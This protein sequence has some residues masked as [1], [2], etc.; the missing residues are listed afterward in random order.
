LAAAIVHGATHVWAIFFCPG[1]LWAGNTPFR[2]RRLILRGMKLPL[3][4]LGAIV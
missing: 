2:G 3:H 1:L 4:L